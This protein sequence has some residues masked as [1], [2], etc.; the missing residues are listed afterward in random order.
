MLFHFLGEKWGP[1][2][3]RR[4]SSSKLRA[5]NT[6]LKVLSTF[7]V[8]ALNAIKNVFTCHTYRNMCALSSL[9]LSRKIFGTY[10]QWFIMKKITLFSLNCKTDVSEWGWRWRLCQNQRQNRSLNT[11]SHPGPSPSTCKQC[12]LRG[13]I[14]LM[15]SDILIDYFMKSRMSEEKKG[16]LI[17]EKKCKNH[18]ERRGPCLLPRK[19][20]KRLVWFFFF[21]REATECPLPL[22]KS[23]VLFCKEV[24]H[25]SAKVLSV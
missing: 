17:S 19:P 9:R 22:W 3:K 11:A 15:C 16:I 18:L 7:Q 2:P 8:R 23:Y 6:L 1:G 14:L 13:Q 12:L 10:L 21:L 5:R 24:T 25:V 20:P 4:Q